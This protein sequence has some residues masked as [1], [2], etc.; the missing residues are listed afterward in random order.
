MKKYIIERYNRIS[1]EWVFVKTFLSLKKAKDEVKF[2]MRHDKTQV[3]RYR[4]V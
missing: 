1:L 2:R 3:Y 4:Y